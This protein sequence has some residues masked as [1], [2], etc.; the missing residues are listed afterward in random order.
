[1]I[2]VA[3]GLE[4]KIHTQDS[5]PEGYVS[6]G[7]FESVLRGLSTKF[8]AD[9]LWGKLLA[10]IG[11]QA[12]MKIKTESGDPVV[13][14]KLSDHA[15]TKPEL[16]VGILQLFFGPELAFRMG[17]RAAISFSVLPGDTVVVT[18]FSPAGKKWV[19]RVSYATL[20]GVKFLDWF[21]AL[22][23]KSGDFSEFS[24]ELIAGGVL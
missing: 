3:P 11:N 22:V 4:S 21:K 16:G 20:E 17:E 24:V 8:D 6:K 19:F 5:F 13:L 10:A 15:L 23:D 14:A 12:V 9:I 2:T 18:L 1:M 7:L